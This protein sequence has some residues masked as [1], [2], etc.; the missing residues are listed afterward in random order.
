MYDYLKHWI[1]GIV[2]K[3]VVAQYLGVFK[4]KDGLL[5]PQG[6][7]SIAISSEAIEMA[8]REVENVHAKKVRGPYKRYV[9]FTRGTLEYSTASRL[10]ENSP[11]SIRRSRA[12]L[13][14]RG[15][16]IRIP[17]HLSTK[18]SETKILLL[19]IPCYEIFLKYGIINFTFL[20]VGAEKRIQTSNYNY[21]L[22]VHSIQWNAG[23]GNTHTLHPNSCFCSFSIPTSRIKFLLLVIKISEI[24]VAISM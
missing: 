19:K 2:F 13:Q 21:V 15:A 9:V 22:Q 11:P 24:G 10:R 3:Y 16:L 7:L 6:S 23:M 17:A 4:P 12:V 14:A 18:I 20:K 8:N 5:D 1:N